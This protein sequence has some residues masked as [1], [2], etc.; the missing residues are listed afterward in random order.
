M[1]VCCPK[2]ARQLSDQLLKIKNHSSSVVIKSI[3]NLFRTR[4]HRHEICKRSSPLEGNKNFNLKL[5][6]PALHC[7]APNQ[8]HNRIRKEGS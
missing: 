8:A 6:S 2:K 1:T 3:P 7:A 5:L 4:L